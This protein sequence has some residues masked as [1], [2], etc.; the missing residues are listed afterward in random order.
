MNRIRAWWRGVQDGWEQPHELNLSRTIDDLIADDWRAL[1][2]D[3]EA[4]NEDWG[5]YATF[6]DY[7]ANLGQVLRKGRKSQAWESGYQP[8]PGCALTM[9]AMIVALMVLG[10]LCGTWLA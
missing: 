9:V 8:L 1:D 7:G 6:Q 10:W 4:I 3:W 2:Q 5:T